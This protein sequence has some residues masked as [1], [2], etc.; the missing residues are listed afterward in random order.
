MNKELKNKIETEVKNF[1]K[2][3]LCASCYDDMEGIICGDIYDCYDSS[4]MDDCW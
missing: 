2:N 1:A 4:V 3:N